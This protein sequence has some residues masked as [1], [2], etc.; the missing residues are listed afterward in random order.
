MSK[1]ICTD[2]ERRVGRDE[3]TTVIDWSRAIGA[4]VKVRALTMQ[5]GWDWN[6]DPKM[7]FTIA[8]IGFRITVDGKC[9][10]IVSLEEVEDRTFTLK[11]LDFI[12]YD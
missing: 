12:S 4:K 8:S 10:T 5:N 2:T 6:Y 7:E 3:A 11:D 1:G 9:H